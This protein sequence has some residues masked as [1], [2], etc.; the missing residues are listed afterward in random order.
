MN[1]T[2][3]F[4]TLDHQN[5]ALSFLRTDKILK[6]AAAVC[7]FLN[8]KTGVKLIFAGSI[9][10]ENK[11]IGDISTDLSSSRLLVTL[12][13]QIYDETKEICTPKDTVLERKIEAVSSPV[14]F[15]ENYSIVYQIKTLDPE[16]MIFFGKNKLSTRFTQHGQLAP[17]FSRLCELGYLPNEELEKYD[18]D[19]ECDFESIRNRKLLNDL[20]K[21]SD[22]C[23]N[24]PFV[25]N[26]VFDD[27]AHF[28]PD[29]IK[30]LKTNPE[31]LQDVESLLA[32][33]CEVYTSDSSNENEDSD[34]A[35]STDSSIPPT[36]SHEEAMSIERLKDLGF[37]EDLALQAYYAC[38]RN[39][40]E[41]AIFLQALA[42]DDAANFFQSIADDDKDT[43]L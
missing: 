19:D 13:P 43:E 16:D 14:P 21:I 28:C 22:Q 38:E 10:E 15:L 41:A 27:F 23:L 36:I 26:S 33:R 1:L 3:N 30:R 11:Q 35:C 40:K 20:Q 42:E 9:L 31:E 24:N 4:Q 7:T 37:S 8:S 32:L 39:E 18:D 6:V 34:S 17:I 12:K 5:F 2:I 29:I 25:M